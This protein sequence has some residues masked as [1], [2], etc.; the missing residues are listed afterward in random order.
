MQ[1]LDAADDEERD[2]EDEARSQIIPAFITVS[3]G[4][5]QACSYFL[6]DFSFASTS[7]Y[8]LCG[9]SRLIHTTS[10]LLKSEMAAVWVIR[11]ELFFCL[12]GD[13]SYSQSDSLSFSATR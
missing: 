1:Q 12:H 9:S 8:N 10:P 7:F 4:S 11:S 2:E 6:V 13:E 5:M 3:I